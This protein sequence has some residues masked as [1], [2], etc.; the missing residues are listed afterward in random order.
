MGFFSVKENV[1]VPYEMLTA[2]AWVD[3]HCCPLSLTLSSL[4]MTSIHVCPRSRDSTENLWPPDYVMSKHQEGFMNSNHLS[5]IHVLRV[6][7]CLSFYKSSLTLGLVYVYSGLCPAQNTILSC[8]FHDIVTYIL[9]FSKT[10]EE[11]GKKCNTFSWVLVDASAFSWK[12][13]MK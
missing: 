11:R 1:S 12:Q 3:L 2:I 7:F 8:W 10:G 9:K 13:N 5:F 6:V 4:S